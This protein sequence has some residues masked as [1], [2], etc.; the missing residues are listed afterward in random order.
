MKFSKWSGALALSLLVFPGAGHF[1]YKR[2]RRGLFWC[3][4]FFLIIIRMLIILWVN[5][6]KIMEG[7][8]ST[9]GDVSIDMTQIGL[10]AGLGLLSFVWWGLA[11]ADTWW[12]ARQEAAT[13]LTAELAERAES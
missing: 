4:P 10:G 1:L 3:A 12:I 8:M 5:V 11:G 6:S 9:T 7:M 13:I 2:W